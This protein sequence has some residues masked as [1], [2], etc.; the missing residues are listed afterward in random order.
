MLGCYTPSHT[1]WPRLLLLISQ[2]G[3]LT[4]STNLDA[5]MLWRQALQSVTVKERAWDMWNMWGGR[6]VIVGQ[7]MASKCAMGHLLIS[8]PS[9]PFSTMLQQS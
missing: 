5:H 4:V 6:Q 1:G 3:M 9:I 7:L 2:A 8:I